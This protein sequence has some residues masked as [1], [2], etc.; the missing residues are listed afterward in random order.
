[1]VLERHQKRKSHFHYLATLKGVFGMLRSPEHTESVFD[2]EDG[3]RDLDATRLAMEHVRKVPEMAAL[4]EERYL[5]DVPDTEKLLDYP[6]GTL[7][8][9]YAHHLDDRGFDPDY[10]RKIDV[11]DDIDYVL[12]R[13]R[14]THDIWHVITG[15]DT[16]RLGEIAI[17]AV[18]LAQTRRP[19]AA[20][21]TTGGVLRYLRKDPEQLGSVLEMISAGYQMG[22][23][24]KL[25]LAQKWE[26]GWDRPLADWR[27]EL[28]VVPYEP[29]G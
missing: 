8:Y 17:K 9:C 2:I 3:L 27:A 14:Q 5:C 25:L 24:A 20:V 6:E 28:N 7:G 26:L 16:D 29:K 18:E 19:M 4:M 10:Y 13:L 21:I 15:F 11:R 12:M 22:I 23:H 1:M